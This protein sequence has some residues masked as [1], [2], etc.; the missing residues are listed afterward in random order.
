MFFSKLNKPIFIYYIMKKS[1]LIEIIILVVLLM[2]IVSF[3]F[4]FF[5]FN[6]FRKDVR[7]I[8]EPEKQ[9][10]IKILNESMNLEDYQINFGNVFTVKDKELAQVQLIKGNSKYYYAVDLNKRRLIRR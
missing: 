10:V 4:P 6:H 2:L 5:Y 7:P 9:E 3:L 1:L 8:T